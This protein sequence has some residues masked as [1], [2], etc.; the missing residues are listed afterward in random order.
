MVKI[1]AGQLQAYEQTVALFGVQEGE[2]ASLCFACTPTLT[3]HMGNLL[4]TV[5]QTFGGKGGGK[6]DFAQGGG[7]AP[8]QLA[9]ALQL[10]QTH[11][12]AD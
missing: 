12:S 8:E 3:L 5:L 4:R 1:L 11:L 7:L 2:K 10:A 6:A 9:T